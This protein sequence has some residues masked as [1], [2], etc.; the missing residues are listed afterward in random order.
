MTGLPSRLPTP[1]EMTRRA[2]DFHKNLEAASGFARKALAFQVLNMSYRLSRSGTSKGG[3]FHCSISLNVMF[4][5][6][7]KRPLFVDPLDAFQT[8]SLAPIQGRIVPC[9]GFHSL[10]R[11]AACGGQATSQRGFTVE[12]HF[13]LGRAAFEPST[14]TKNC[15]VTVRG[16]HLFSCEAP[17]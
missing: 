3:T 14:S 12:A 9:E 17:K 6:V 4:L 7:L 8:R 15:C 16:M 10:G 5:H 13:Q 1:N 2:M 11:C